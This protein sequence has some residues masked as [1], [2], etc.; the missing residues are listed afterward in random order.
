MGFE[1]EV[2]GFEVL[3][4]GFDG[5]AL[6]SDVLGLEPLL[7]SSLQMKVG[8]LLEPPWLEIV[9]NEGF[10][11]TFDDAFGWLARNHCGVEVRDSADWVQGFRIGG[12]WVRGSGAGVRCSGIG[13]QGFRLWF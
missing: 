10:E 5:S 9:Q 12:T 6:G 7:T 13:I 8:L 2:L 3:A 1:A 4:L 11:T